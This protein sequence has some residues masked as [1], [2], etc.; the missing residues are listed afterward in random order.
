MAPGYYELTY[1]N[2]KAL[3]TKSPIHEIKARV[4]Y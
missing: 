4:F 3:L 1:A 2:S